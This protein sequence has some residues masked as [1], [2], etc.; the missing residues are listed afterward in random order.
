MRVIRDPLEEVLQYQ[1]TEMV[2]K[3]YFDSTKPFKKRL[4]KNAA[5][6]IEK[7]EAQIAQAANEKQ[8]KI[9]NPD[10]VNLYSL[11]RVKKNLNNAFISKYQRYFKDGKLYM[12]ELLR[13]MAVLKEVSQELDL[14]KDRKT[15]PE[16]LIRQC[17]AE[18]QGLNYVRI[19][20]DEDGE[21]IE[22]LYDRKNLVKFLREKI[23]A[24]GTAMKFE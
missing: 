9:Q 2:Q 4:F 8:D 1:Q 18:L 3:C 22:T 16:M 5:Q 23:K 10:E 7:Q 6:E 24:A 12:S 13:N 15:T 11:K 14:C 20:E 19:S 17:L 21:L